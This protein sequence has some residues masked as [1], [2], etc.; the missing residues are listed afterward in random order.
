MEKHMT[1]RQ[2]W[3]DF[4]KV[5]KDLPNWKDKTRAQKAPAY[6]A[7]QAYANDHLGPV[8]VKRLLELYAPERYEID[9]V[10]KKR[11]P[12]TQ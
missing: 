9:I 11:E 6:V 1:H 12:P 8:R 5:K 10:F 2:A 3:E 4:W 7:N